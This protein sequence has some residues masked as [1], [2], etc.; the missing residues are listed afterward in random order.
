MGD[1]IHS[2]IVPPLLKRKGYKVHF[3]VDTQFAPIVEKNPFIDLV[4]PI[5]LRQLKGIKNWKEKWHNGWKLFKWLQGF[6]YPLVLDL[7]G[8]I[9]S[10]I[11]SYLISARS[12]SPFPTSNSPF[13]LPIFQTD[14]PQTDNSSSSHSSFPYPTSTETHLSNFFPIQPIGNTS[15]QKSLEVDTFHSPQPTSPIRIGPTPARERIA[16][17]FYTQ[18]VKIDPSQVATE[19]YIKIAGIEEREF[20][21]NHPKLIGYQPTHFPYLSNYRKNVAFIIGSTWE[22]RKLPIE[23]WISIGKGLKGWNILI[24]YYNEKE[25][26]YGERIVEKTGGELLRLPLHLLKALLSQVDLIIGHD[27]GPTFIGWA[28]N[29]PN[30]ILYTCTYRNKIL[31]NRWCRSVEVQRGKVDR[32]LY[33]GNLLKANQVLERIEELTK[34]GIIG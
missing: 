33:N 14:K 16:E 12:I 30:I 32:H 31:E 34:E 27:T 23:T 21:T 19:R 24:P 5:P 2:L 17:L 26:E 3:F 9:K 4:V 11:I 28:N 1:V 18:K 29:I 22:C 6:N 13:S 25:R 15:S 20:L 8:L 10:G 7:Q